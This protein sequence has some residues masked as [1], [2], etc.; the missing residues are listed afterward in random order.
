MTR[1]IY[2]GAVKRFPPIVIIDTY[3]NDRK[4]AW[5]NFTH[6]ISLTFISKKS[7]REAYQK[8]FLDKSSLKISQV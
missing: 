1:C 5:F 2:C 8:T 6:L 7:N 4:T 3:L